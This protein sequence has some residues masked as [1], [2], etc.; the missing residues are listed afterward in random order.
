MNKKR[1]RLLII[2][3]VVAIVLSLIAG[4]TYIA[5]NYIFSKVTET[6]GETMNGETVD[7]PVLD[8]NQQIV[9]NKHVSVVLD[10]KTIKELEAKIPIS[11]KLEILAMLAQSL[12][13][14]EYSKLMSYAVGGVNNE[15]FNAAY[16]LMR[17]S[18][19]PEE[20]AKIKSY[21]IK[22]LYLLEE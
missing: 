4:G 18:L 21:Y 13:P 15:K 5:V 22:Y 9:D 6:V 8:S 7:L 19:E 16:A 1:K 10:E 14:E 3:I 2:L 20:K 11:E 17:E 12:E